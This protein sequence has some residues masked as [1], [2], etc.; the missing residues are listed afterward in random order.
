MQDMRN[1]FNGHVAQ[2]SEEDAARAPQQLLQQ[3]Q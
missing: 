3:Q 1:Y 2:W